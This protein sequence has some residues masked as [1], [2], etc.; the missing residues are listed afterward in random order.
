MDVKTIRDEIAKIDQLLAAVDADMEKITP[1]LQPDPHLVEHEYMVLLSALS[2]AA[3]PFQSLEDEESVKNAGLDAFTFFGLLQAFIDDPLVLKCLGKQFSS[4]VG[5]T[6]TQ[7]EDALV[8]AERI[9]D[10]ESQKNILLAIIDRIVLEIEKGKILNF[11]IV[12]SLCQRAS[13]TEPNAS[14]LRLL[15]TRGWENWPLFVQI[16]LAYYFRPFSHEVVIVD[17]FSACVVDSVVGED[18]GQLEKNTHLHSP[19]TCFQLLELLQDNKRRKITFEKIIAYVEKCVSRTALP[20]PGQTRSATDWHSLVVSMARLDFFKNPT[21]PVWTTLVDRLCA[22]VPPA[23]EVSGTLSAL[24]SVGVS[25]DG[26]F[27]N[28]VAFKRRISA[29]DLTKQ[30]F[31]EI[32]HHL[33]YAGDR[34]S[35][36]ALSK[37]IMERRDLFV[38]P[39]DQPLASSSFVL[40]SH[41][42]L[43]AAVASVESGSIIPESILILKK[44]ALQIWTALNDPDLFMCLMQL[45]LPSADAESL[46]GRSLQALPLPEPSQSSD[47]VR[48]A[49]HA[50]GF[51]AEIPNA[52][53]ACNVRIQGVCADFSFASHRIAILVDQN[54]VFNTAAKRHLVS[55]P[56]ALKANIFTQ[57]KGFKVIVVV[58]ELYPD[59]KSLVGLLADPLKRLQPNAVF[60]LNAAEECKLSVN[61]RMKNFISLTP[62][63]VEIARALFLILKLSVQ[64]YEFRFDNVVCGDQFASLVFCEFLP[65]YV[66]KHKHDISV[67]CEGSGISS[68]TLHKIVEALNASGNACSG[69]GRIRLNL[70]L[71]RQ[72]K[73]AVLSG[74]NE[75]HVN[76]IIRLADSATDCQLESNVIML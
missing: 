12:A 73:D 37:A 51:S 32:V 70:S 2:T 7:L 24:S 55:G 21:L 71:Q 36:S 31:S 15:S 20:I 75:A 16:E 44:F 4:I 25:S 18:G 72:K 8:I 62:S 27:G 10:G 40:L 54:G 34:S 1:E 60:V 66:V 29:P 46:I 69:F 30:D 74:W 33:I 17:M 68:E 3:G 6:P 26:L 65:T 13:L 48:R 47:R 56:V 9:S 59:E 67:T 41:V 58:P 5:V 53:L 57:R 14:L 38:P 50:V 64:V 23:F 52:E 45:L 61:Q 42:V 49:L 19:R 22:N 11:A 35:G 28:L 39:S 63:L 43:L 76:S